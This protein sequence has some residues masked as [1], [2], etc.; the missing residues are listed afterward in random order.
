[1]ALEP[2]ESGIGRWSLAHPRCSAQGE[3]LLPRH[4]EVTQNVVTVDIASKI[5]E[6]QEGPFNV[7]QF[8]TAVRR[9]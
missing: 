6:Q 7:S 5:I 2:K 9:C 1:M 8:V 3:Q 4:S